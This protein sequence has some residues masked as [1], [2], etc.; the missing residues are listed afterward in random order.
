M[1]FP[2]PFVFVSLR[3]LAKN[4]YLERLAVFHLPHCTN[5][6]VYVYTRISTL[7]QRISDIK[8]FFIL[9]ASEKEN[10]NPLIYSWQPGSV[11]LAE[12]KVH[13]FLYV[14]RLCLFRLF[15]SNLS[16]LSDGA[17]CVL[18]RNI[19]TAYTF[20]CRLKRG[21][22]KYILFDLLLL[23]SIQLLAQLFKCPCSVLRVSSFVYKRSCHSDKWE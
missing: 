22:T 14:V 20:Y 5:F 19:F 23:Q 2:N 3:Q 6:Y 13:L 8:D 12:G 16:W 4:N 17:R 15:I 21:C 9:G 18:R 11:Y 10:F 7:P 1:H